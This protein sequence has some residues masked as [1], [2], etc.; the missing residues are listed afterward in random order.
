MTFTFTVSST[1]ALTTY[2]LYPSA[3]LLASTTATTPTLVGW[4]SAPVT[5]TILQ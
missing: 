1:A 3:A 2:Q 4:S 5:L